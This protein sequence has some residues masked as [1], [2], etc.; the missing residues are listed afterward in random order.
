[1]WY[2]KFGKD[3]KDRIIY[4]WID[5]RLGFRYASHGSFWRW[6]RF[7]FIRDFNTGDINKTDGEEML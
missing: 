3:S 4:Q 5:T 6:V 2:P 7:Y 1:M